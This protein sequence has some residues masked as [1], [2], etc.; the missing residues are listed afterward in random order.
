M[1]VYNT[2]YN[3]HYGFGKGG[4]NEQKCSDCGGE[5]FY[6][7]MAWSGEPGIF[8]CS[9]CCLGAKDGLIAD[10]IHFAAVV[11]MREYHAHDTLVRRSRRSLEA[12]GEREG[13]A[14]K[15][16]RTVKNDAAR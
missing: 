4:H 15:R 5:L 13:E 12:E 6:P 8:L 11:Q 1:G 16:I 2:K 10:L 3:D 7:F 14:I 9:K